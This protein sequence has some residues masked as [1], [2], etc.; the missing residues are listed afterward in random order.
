MRDVGGQ[1][2]NAGEQVMTVNN[3]MAAFEFALALYPAGRVA[4]M[5]PRSAA[6]FWASM[7]EQELLSLLLWGV[8]W[9]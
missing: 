8:S 3:G 7:P 4:N 6:P 1:V 9:A 2:L 5:L